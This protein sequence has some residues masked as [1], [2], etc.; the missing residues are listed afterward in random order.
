MARIAFIIIGSAALLGTFALGQTEEEAGKEP[1][2]KIGQEDLKVEDGAAPKKTPA[3]KKIEKKKSPPHIRRKLKRVPRGHHEIRF[4][5]NFGINYGDE[6][7]Q[8]GEEKKASEMTSQAYLSVFQK[9]KT[10]TNFH[11]YVD[12]LSDSDQVIDAV[13]IAKVDR[14]FNSHFSFSLG[15]NYLNVGGFENKALRYDELAVSSYT[16]YQLPF[17]DV[18]GGRSA[19]VIQSDVSFSWLGDISLQITEDVV[20]ISEEDGGSDADWSYMNTRQRQPVGIVQWSVSFGQIV[21]QIQVSSYDLN[22]SL[23]LGAG[24]GFDLWILSGYFDYAVDQRAYR[25]D[26]E[27]KKIEF[28]NMVAKI[29]FDL[30]AVVPFIK[31]SQLTAEQPDIDGLGNSSEDSFDD[32]SITMS[33]GFYMKSSYTGDAFVPYLG[34]MHKSQNINDNPRDPLSVEAVTQETY[35][36]GAKGTL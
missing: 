26:E 31:Y 35:T 32:N 30:G 14:K 11:A 12:L 27:E 15:R 10:N 34:Y 36:I 29:E 19:T 9:L 18:N 17:S 1:P 22:H 23:Y 28:S 6:S 2:T 5:Y 16:A 13:D 25:D 8:S 4:D 33:G 20:S 21:P 24:V 3:L 7:F